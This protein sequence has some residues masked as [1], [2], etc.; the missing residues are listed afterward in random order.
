MNVVPE[1]EIAVMIPVL[2]RNP[3]MVAVQE[4]YVIH[5]NSALAVLASVFQNPFL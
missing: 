4:E 1:T 3:L 5:L 2:I